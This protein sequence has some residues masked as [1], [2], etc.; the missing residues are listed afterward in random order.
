[1]QSVMLQS[2][3][4]PDGILKL[5]IPIGLPDVE[6]EVM[7]I[8]QPLASNPTASLPEAQGWPAGFFEQTAGA[9]EGERL[10]R[11]SQGDDEF[12][13]ELG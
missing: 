9:W 4:G 3:V 12:R 5:Q 11:E 6:V 8:M 10:V 13:N 7:V 1:M 2:R